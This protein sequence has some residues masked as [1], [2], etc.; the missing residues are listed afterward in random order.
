MP[1]RST[2][3][4]DM[5]KT[6]IENGPYQS[7]AAE[8]QGGASRATYLVSAAFSKEVAQNG[9]PR[10]ASKVRPYGEAW[11]SVADIKKIKLSADANRWTGGA[12][13][14]YTPV[15]TFS[16]RFTFGADILGADRAA[17]GPQVSDDDLQREGRV[18]CAEFSSAGGSREALYARLQD[19]SSL[20]SSG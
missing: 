15:A 7:Y 5:N 16:N 12:T 2:R 6:L 10:L 14:T 19:P 9:D 20:R 13:L 18:S 3:A 4:L 17:Q 11:I 8:V 1:S